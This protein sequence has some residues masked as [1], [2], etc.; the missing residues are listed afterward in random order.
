MTYVRTDRRTIPFRR[1]FS[2]QK[3]ESKSQNFPLP[4]TAQTKWHSWTRLSNVKRTDIK[5]K[6]NFSLTILANST[7]NYTCMSSVDVFLMF[8]PLTLCW[9]LFFG[10][11]TYTISQ[12]STSYLSFV[13]QWSSVAVMTFIWWRC[14][15][16]C[17]RIRVFSGSH[18]PVVFQLPVRN[19]FVCG[20]VNL[21]VLYFWHL[22][23]IFYGKSWI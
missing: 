9:R 14:L 18:S 13:F 11:S 20:V 21:R 19:M 1:C 17:R 16:S 3:P 10:G 23:M 2:H 6:E 7:H 4:G 15:H 8:V 22:N 12:L 5:C